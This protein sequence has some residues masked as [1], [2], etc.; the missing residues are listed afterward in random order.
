MNNEQRTTNYEL[1]TNLAGSA[2]ILTVVLTTL[3]AIVGVTFV[4]VA[5]V[6]K[7]ATS[8]I[9]ENKQLNL[10]VDSVVARICDQL[11]SDV[12][13][14]AL[15]PVIPPE[16]Y[17][18]Y[19]NHRLD[20]GPDGTLGTQD[21][22]P[23]A[24]GSNGQYDKGGAD[25]IPVTGIFDNIW[26]ANL[27]P[28]IV[29]VGLDKGNT[30]LAIG[31]RHITDLY[32]RVAY[33]F[34]DSFDYGTNTISWYDSDD[35][36]ISF[37]NMAA[38]IIPESQS[39][40]NE[41]DKAD[42]D[43]DGV[44]DSRWVSVPDMTSKGRDVYAAVRIVD[45]GGMLNV[46]T[47]YKFDSADPGPNGEYV[48]GSSQM[49]INLLDLAGR[50]TSYT[51]QEEHDRL[52]AFRGGSASAPDDISAYEYNVVRRYDKPTGLYTPFDISDELRLRNRYIINYNKITTRIEELWTNAYEGGPSGPLPTQLYPLAR[53]PNCT[54]LGMVEPNDYD[55]RHIST[56]YNMDRIIDPGGFK[57]F[58]I[59]RINPVPAEPNVID[60]YRAIRVDIGDDSM[61]AQIAANIKDYGDAD[62]DVTVVN[63]QYGF[64]RPC[65]CISELS[66]HYLLEQ[67]EMGAPRPAEHISYAIELRQR[68]WGA[69]NNDEWRVVISNPA[70]DNPIYIDVTNFSRTQNRYRVIVFEDPCAS[71]AEDVLYSDSPADGETG[72]D[73][74]VTLR[75]PQ[76][77]LEP[78]EW[79]N[80]SYD[81]YFG[82]DY[83]SVSDANN[84]SPEFIDNFAYDVNSYYPGPLST[85]TPYFWR[86]DDID[87][88]SNVIGSPDVW[89]FTTWLAE[90]NSIYDII[91]PNS[92]RIF[93]AGT[94]ISLERILPDNTGLRVDQFPRL[95]IGENVMPPV[96]LPPVGQ[97][98]PV[99]PEPPVEIKISIKRD[100]S[101]GS[102]IKRIWDDVTPRPP[103]LGNSTGH[104]FAAGLPIP[105][106]SPI[107][108]RPANQFRNVGEIGL[109]L[110]KSAYLNDPTIAIRPD[111]DELA[112][113]LNLADPDVQQFFRYLTR[114]DPST[115][116]VDNDGDG[117]LDE[118][119]G[120]ELKIA[121]RININTAP[122]YVIA[123]LPWV[124][125]HI[126]N[127]ELARAIVAY[128][129]KLDLSA[130][131]AGGPDYFNGRGVA[132]N[133]AMPPL[134]REE[135]GFA[136]IG[137]LNNVIAGNREY[138]MRYYLGDDDQLTYPD[139]TAGGGR[140]LGDG[141][142]DDFEE[143]DLIFARISDLV[144]VRSDVFTAYILVRMGTDGPQKRVIAILDRSDVYPTTG[145]RVK[146]RALYQVPDP[147]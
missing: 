46:N 64:E 62:C 85:N 124:S 2:L 44:A 136:S 145:G 32:G 128:R 57:M 86:I 69:N 127:Y 141:Y 105:E 108:A 15:P 130:L 98:A 144:T 1:R 3:L 76:L 63:G 83:N 34:Q 131:P 56:T 96:M 143:R 10:A 48:D 129:D 117:T 81:V 115:D 123:Q 139:L 67:Q 73:P 11:A 116:G 29:D 77:Q 121:G 12:P 8:A 50:G 125:S 68:Y 21:D 147:R 118:Q 133:P 14:A 106:S 84:S 43:G 109:V 90:P 19:P 47:G 66:Y 107:Q 54:I 92:P 55:Y 72:V 100:V 80:Y 99:A 52:L 35:D 49:Q 101:G 122:W 87:P 41:G 30:E 7:T 16:E 104:Y 17:Y 137:E 140:S 88:N 102:W 91:G 74:D 59:N 31:F 78:N 120:S 53:W 94:V 134:L 142:P 24:P 61:A 103:S 135:P 27:E 37:R 26:L 113:R 111:D 119:D 82:T 138:G 25:D 132:I 23:Y 93:E 20:P 110:R 5:R 75:W 60:L 9:A 146:I 36:R 89:T 28:E 126:P 22:S 39:I 70:W 51:P 13:R 71:L 33:M 114:F 38:T 65:I 112:A 97:L 95:Y 18:D 79:P 40:Q 42:A 45:N 6:D 58:N 4:L